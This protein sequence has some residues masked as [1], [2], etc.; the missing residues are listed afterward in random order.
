[1]ARTF[2]KQDHVLDS[3]LPNECSLYEIVLNAITL[4]IDPFVIRAQH[5]DILSAFLV[6]FV[7][8]EIK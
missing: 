3:I 6:S 7:N 8:L 1:M 4:K 2:L 5:E